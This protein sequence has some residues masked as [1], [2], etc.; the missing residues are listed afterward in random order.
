[1]SINGFNETTHRTGETYYVY[2]NGV[3]NRL[4]SIFHDLIIGL[5]LRMPRESI[6]SLINSHAVFADFVQTLS[7]CLCAQHTRTR[8]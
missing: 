3:E 7:S 8:T 5:A 6:V 1:M 4:H 2:E